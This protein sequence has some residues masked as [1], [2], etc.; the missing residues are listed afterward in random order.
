MKIGILTCEKLP[1]L[2]EAEQFLIPALQDKKHD[3]NAVI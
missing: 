3:V 1:N 2:L